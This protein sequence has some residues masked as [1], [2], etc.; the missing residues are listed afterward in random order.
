VF[1][2]V[3]AHVGTLQSQ[4]KK[5]VIALWSEGSRD[6]MGAMLRDHKLLNVTNVNTWRMVQDY[7][8]KYY[9]P[10]NPG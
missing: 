3:V 5:V 4:R 7:T 9:L 1:E 10:P 8:K 6:R 2:S